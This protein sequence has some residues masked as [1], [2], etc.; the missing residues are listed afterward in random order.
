MSIKSTEELAVRKIIERMTALAGY[1]DTPE[2]VC[3]VHDLLFATPSG[4]QMLKALQANLGLAIVPSD[5]C[6][7][8][9]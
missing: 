1:C 7:P 6:L 5:T 2:K 9:A 3:K 4:E 8:L